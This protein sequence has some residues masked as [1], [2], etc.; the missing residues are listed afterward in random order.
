LHVFNGSQCMFNKYTIITPTLNSTAK[1]KR[2]DFTTVDRQC[3]IVAS[4]AGDDVSPASD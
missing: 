2:L 1:M 4:K 3:Y